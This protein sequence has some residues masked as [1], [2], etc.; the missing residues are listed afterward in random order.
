MKFA[1]SAALVTTSLMSVPAM[2]QE[3]NTG[4][5]VSLSAGVASVDDLDVT[6][7]DGADTVDF[8]FDMKSAAVFR[9]AVGY[10][11]GMVRADVE[12]S[13]HRNKVSSVTLERVNGTAITLDAA[14]RADV[15]DFLEAD[16]CGGSGNTFTTDGTSRARQLSALANIWIDLP[17]GPVTPYAGGGVG[18]TGYELD[19]EG[20]ARFAWQLGAGTAFN[21]TSNIAITGDY[22]YREAGGVTLEDEGLRLGKVKTHTFSAGFRFGF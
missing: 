14:D 17:V 9:G 19:G 11:F 16:S 6:Y 13:Y 10:D 12:V 7:F 5:Y 20:K 22:R 15:C 18:V 4:A 2:A 1:V 3:D 21:V 8:S